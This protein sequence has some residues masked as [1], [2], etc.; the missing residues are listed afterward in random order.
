MAQRYN[1]FVAT[2]RQAKKRKLCPI[3]QKRTASPWQ[4]ADPVI[5]SHAAAMAYQLSRRESARHALIN[6][7][8][9]IHAVIHA[10]GKTRDTDTAK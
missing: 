7:P 2:P 8:E 10:L 1:V 9:L 4:D 3:C 6:S 5:V